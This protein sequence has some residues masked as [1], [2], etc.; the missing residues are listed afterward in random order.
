MKLLTSDESIQELKKMEHSFCG[1]TTKTL[2]LFLCFCYVSIGKSIWWEH[3]NLLSQNCINCSTAVVIAIGIVEELR[4]LFH[5]F[6]LSR[7]CLG[8]GFFCETHHLMKKTSFIVIIMENLSDPIL[9]HAIKV[10][11]RSDTSVRTRIQFSALM[12]IRQKPLRFF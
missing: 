9:E 4:I 1:W 7:A 3:G 10:V 11:I 2:I 8:L 6:T 12:V 5:C